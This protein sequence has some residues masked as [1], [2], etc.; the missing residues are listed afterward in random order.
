MIKIIR[1][2]SVSILNKMIYFGD[3]AADQIFKKPSVSVLD[4]SEPDMLNQH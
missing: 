3:G 1:L 2:K 4:I